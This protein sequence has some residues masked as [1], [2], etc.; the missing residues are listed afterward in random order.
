MKKVGADVDKKDHEKI[1][2]SI[3]RIPEIIIIALMIVVL[4][5][6]FISVITRYIFGRAIYWAEEIGSFGLA[7]ITMIGTS[8]A[9]KRNLHFT[10]PTF[11]ASLTG[12]KKYAF[13]IIT[14]VL[15]IIFA[16]I[17]ISAGYDV[18]RNS[19]TMTS[20]ALEINLGFMNSS[21]ILG[22][23]LILIYTIRQII[24]MIGKGRINSQDEP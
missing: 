22:G 13:A 24:Q 6:M 1:R 11:I 7:W 8:V 4:F 18:M 17:M 14:R 23:I 5:D 2:K 3:F 15:I 12:N 9:V 20:P 19:M 10:M 21:A 16:I